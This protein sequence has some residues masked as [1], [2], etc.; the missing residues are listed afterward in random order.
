M[1]AKEAS[2]EWTVSGGGTG[3]YLE[4]RLEG[5]CDLYDAPRFA[6]AALA[7]VAGGATRLRLDFSGV[8][9]LD[10]TGVGA[11][12][13]ILQAARKSGCEVRFRGIA[14]SP[15]RVLEMSSVISLMKEDAPLAAGVRL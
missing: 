15:R 11:I 14:G 9:Y 4:Y 10:S 12:I 3:L 2:M 8:R 1:T 6:T 5:D 13:R 7:S